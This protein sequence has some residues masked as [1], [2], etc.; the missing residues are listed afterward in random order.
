[1]QQ[2]NAP[3]LPYASQ[4]TYALP[5]KPAKAARTAQ[6]VEEALRARRADIERRCRELSPPLD[7]GALPH[8][9]SF[10]ATMQIAQPMTDEFWE[11]FLKPRILTE[12][13]A[14]EA[15][16]RMR[17]D[18]MVWLQAAVPHSAHDEPFSR[19]AKE[20]Y[21][22]DFEDAQEPLR[23]K[24]SEYADDF[25]NNHWRGGQLDKTS[26]PVFA[27]KVIEFVDRRYREDKLAGVLPQPEQSSRG[28]KQ[29]SP[30]PDPFLSLHNMKWVYDNKI[31]PRTDVHGRELF[32]CSG[33]TD[34]KQPK[35]L[36]FEGLI[37]HYGAKHTTAF[38]Q[39][40][41]VVHWQTAEWPS[42]LP[43]VRD[44]T[45]YMKHEKKA[46]D[47]K[48]HG[49]A[50]RTP[51]T[52]STPFSAPSNEKL[53]S[54]TPVFSRQH[55]SH[56]AALAYYQP[57]YNVYLH[58]EPQSAYG[59]PQQIAASNEQQSE[60]TYEAQLNVLSGEISATWDSL[61]GVKED[62]LLPCIRIQASLHHAVGSFEAT[63]GKIP[64]LDHIT[65][66][67][68]TKPDVKAVKEAKGLAC[69]LCVAAQ[70]DGSASYSGYY[71]RI[72]NVK[73]YNT[74]SL[75]SH[76]SAVHLNQNRGLSSDWIAKMVELPEP[77]MIARLLRA[78]G[79]DDAKLSIL[80][81]AFPNA[82]PYPLP[83]IG[84]VAEEQPENLL[85]QKML[86]RHFK[87]KSEP[88]KKKKKG[89]HGANGTPAREESEPLPEAR[90][91]EYDPRRPMALPVPSGTSPTSATAF[92]FAPETLAALSQLNASSAPSGQH[93]NRTE[94]SPSVGRAEPAKHPVPDISHILAQLTGQAQ[95]IST[96]S[97]HVATPPDTS[98]SRG[99]SQPKHF[100]HDPYSH[101]SQTA[102]PHRY[103]DDR[104]TSSR[105]PPQPQQSY[106]PS[107]E[108]PLAARRDD[109]ARDTYVRPVQ[110]YNAQHFE[111]NRAQPYAEQAY[112]QTQPRSPPQ[113]QPQPQ[114]HYRPIYARHTPTPPQQQQYAHPAA[115]SPP[116]FAPTYRP[117]YVQIPAWPDRDRDRYAPSQPLQYA[118]AHS[119]PQP[120]P[121]Y[122]DAHGRELRLVPM[123]LHYGVVPHALE[124]QYAPAPAAA[125][126]YAS[127]PPAPQHAPQY[128]A[129]YPTQ[130]AHYPYEEG[131]AEQVF[132]AA[133][134][135]Q[136]EQGV[137]FENGRGDVVR[138]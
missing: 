132:Y 56:P 61:D 113:P 8:M 52:N 62:V 91:D 96:E 94:R 83:K 57:Q 15:A 30:M 120:Q 50:R 87:K 131:R 86:D 69:Q 82:F 73:L 41:V 31:R 54:D 71:G 18:H 7:P 85:A 22:K 108:P 115:V 58:D 79:M 109:Q 135:R 93:D 32:L 80:A 106:R 3:G 105:Y 16:E 101:Q 130:F 38:S 9:A 95:S 111:H 88:P 74:S 36:A 40:N 26:S 49:R 67:L 76:F 124:Q 72:Q 59:W 133:A 97:Q 129:Q 47:A 21:D 11:S 5:S 127:S 90:D 118:H 98:T 70:T 112:P 136:Y 81:A 1:M 24:L 23:R 137:G 68:V 104:P 60:S 12:R 65:D 119:P 64:N 39:G 33:C 48:G 100:F 126:G 42:E 28:T 43:F 17:Q 89:Q 2:S 4:P 114:P 77:E 138:R 34:S 37:Q 51:Q 55:S 99:S 20:V 123:P 110:A 103:A 14:A 63:F 46:T 53:L 10:S 19:P 117:E 44:P 6:D 125:A 27:V 121:K 92:N 107:A 13:D 78:P 84:F 134:P 116:A 122:V 102:S 29:G 128:A 75:V 66:V 35:W 45:Y 25:I